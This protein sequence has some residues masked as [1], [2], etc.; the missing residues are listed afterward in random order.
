[1]ERVTGMGGLFFRARDPE[2]LGRW[3]AERL[4]VAGPPGQDGVP[5]WQEA[6]PT[7][8]APFSADTD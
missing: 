2:S 5:W 8:F 4:G 7:V 6:G 3:Y 1:M